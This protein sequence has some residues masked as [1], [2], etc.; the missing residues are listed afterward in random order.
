MNESKTMNNRLL[1]CACAVALP[2]VAARGDVGVAIKGG[3]LGV[4]ADVSVS[5]PGDRFNVRLNGNLLNFETDQEYS[6][7]DYTIDLDVAS[8]GLLIDWF[9]TASE[10][11]ISA[12]V[13]HVDDDNITIDSRQ[14]TY[15][16]GG[17]TY[18]AAQVGVL[19]GSAR[20]DR[21]TAPYLGVGYGNTVGKDGR[22]QWFFDA[23]ALFTGSP[24][25]ALR[26]EGG[27][28][29][30]EPQLIAQVEAE[31]REVQDDLDDISVYPVVAFGI[32]YRF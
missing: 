5:L 12:G 29:S 19:R 24:D 21:S 1:I 13:Y 4:G 18:T 20:L 3:T 14:D 11:R 16:F 15:E 2:C 26:A 9:P 25:V 7:D 10:F 8:V 28:L 30:N 27:T 22:W 6:D 32:A 23:G 17:V 31:R